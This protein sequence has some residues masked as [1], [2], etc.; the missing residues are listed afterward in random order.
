MQ[1][2]LGERQAKKQSL[3]LNVN[4]KNK[5]LRLSIFRSNK[6]I[7]AQI[8]DDEKKHTLVAASSRDIAKEKNSK[9]NQAKLIG[10]ALAQKAKKVKIKNIYFDKRR[11]PYK[12]RIKALCEGAR[13]G[14]LNF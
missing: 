2:K 5:R 7:Y 4:M 9:T 6:Y 13:E 14:G 8:I 12:G 11:F 10:L 3:L 1:K